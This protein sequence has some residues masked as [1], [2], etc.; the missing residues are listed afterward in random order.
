MKL[1]IRRYAWILIAG[2][3]LAACEVSEPGKATPPPLPTQS[4]PEQPSPLGNPTAVPAPQEN[5]VA[6][7][8]AGPYLAPYPAP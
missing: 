6:P 2:T 8:I 4:S 5:N 3:L 1:L 7:T